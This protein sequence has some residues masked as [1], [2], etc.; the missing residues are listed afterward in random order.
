MKSLGIAAFLLLA[1]TAVRVEAKSLP[2]PKST[3][4]RDTQTH[5]TPFVR[6]PRAKVPTPVR[7]SDRKT[8]HDLHLSH[9]VR[10]N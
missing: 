10:G 8:G 5:V 4:D 7:D 6:G 2:Q 1:A 3:I 9:G